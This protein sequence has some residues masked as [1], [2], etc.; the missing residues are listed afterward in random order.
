MP[1][2]ES[3][4]MQLRLKLR[5]SVRNPEA[6]ELYSLGMFAS[7][8][9]KDEEA[10]TLNA[11]AR[12]GQW[13]S[14]ELKLRCRPHVPSSINCW[15]FTTTS[16]ASGLQAQTLLAWGKCMPHQL[17]ASQ[18][19]VKLFDIDGAAQGDVTLQ[20]SAE[21]STALL[22]AL[23]TGQDPE[24]PQGRELMQRMVADVKRALKRYQ[25]MADG[26]Y[27]GVRSQVSQVIF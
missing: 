11:E 20:L 17:L 13:C 9:V 12:I 15:L 21:S 27:S 26:A 10:N 22:S 23:G 25:P 3:I 14:A 16:D 18:H 7:R 1:R 2:P 5:L 8:D 4:A 24:P 6:R 19:C